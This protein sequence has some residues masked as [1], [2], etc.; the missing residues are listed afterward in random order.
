M[1]GRIFTAL[2]FS[3]ILIAYPEA[4]DSLPTQPPKALSEIILPTPTGPSRVGRVSVHWIEDSA[5][6][7]GVA[8]TV[9]RRELMA[10]LWYPANGVNKG[11][12]S[13]FPQLGAIESQLKKLS[14][15]VFDRLKLVRSHAIAEAKLST[16]RPRYPVLIFLHGFSM[17]TFL[18]ASQNEELASHGYVVVGVDS[19]D[20]ASSVIFPDGRLIA[21]KPLE[22]LSPQEQ[23]ER[24][25]QATMRQASDILI[26]LDKLTALNAHDPIGRFTGRLDLN[27]VGVIGHSSGGRAAV[28]AGSIDPR[29]KAGLTLSGSPEPAQLS[30]TGT[31][32]PFMF[33]E[34][35]DNLRDPSDEELTARGMTREKY[36]AR[37]ESHI[38]QRQR[39]VEKAT[40]SVGYLIVVRGAR[41]NSFSD[42]PFLFPEEYRGNQLEGARVMRVINDYTMAF[43]DSQLKGKSIKLHNRALLDPE[44]LT[45]VYRFET[46]KWNLSGGAMFCPGLSKPFCN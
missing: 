4:Q 46:K 43:F 30:E 13:Y 35:F 37:I 41:H 9:E 3:S 24:M 27:R 29:I 25:N 44:I 38:R 17:S 33:M 10:H 34:N 7:A 45:G 40:R 12:A 21:A 11:P 2:I 36:N 6:I 19:P 28:Y 42:T 22:G 31:T 32:K 5:G 8:K 15:T 23:M 26:V 1:T 16:T 14:D 18:Y 20:V 39:I